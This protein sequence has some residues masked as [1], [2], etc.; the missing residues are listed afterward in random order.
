PHVGMGRRRVEV[1]VVLLDVLAMV[2]LAVREPEQSFLEDRVAAVPQR[3][4][5]TQALP[6]V[7]DPAEAILAPAVCAGPGLVVPEVIPRVPVAAVILADRAP[8][9]L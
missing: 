2:A 4:G 5:E 1:E 8:L 9:S 7:R 3:E 6:V